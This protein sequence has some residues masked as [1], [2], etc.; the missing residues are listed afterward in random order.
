M[1]L[2]ISNSFFCLMGI[3]VPFAAQQNAAAAENCPL[4]VSVQQAKAVAL[5]DEPI[6][7]TVSFKNAASVE[8][9]ISIAYPSLSGRGYPGL[10]IKST[11]SPASNTVV[12]NFE[13]NNLAS[14]VMIPANSSWTV[15]VYLQRFAPPPAEANAEMFWSLQ[16]PCIDQRGQQ[17]GSVDQHGAVSIR[18]EQ[19][20]P[21]DL[22][23]I[24]QHYS[25]ISGTE[26]SWELQEKVEALSVFPSPVVI[27][28]LV[29][30]ARLGY[31]EQA[32]R[33]LVKFKD[34]EQARRMVKTALASG[35]R[36]T[37]RAALQVS[38]AW[39]EPLD[40]SY[41]DGLLESSKGAVQIE[42]LQYI[43]QS[44]DQRYAPALSRLASSSDQ[45]VAETAKQVLSQLQLRRR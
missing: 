17:T 45:S 16:T 15:S 2:I 42:F 14:N 32:Y 27:P 37:V 40:V 44:E 34:N 9:G 28:E 7:L 20:T 10:S 18:T 19:G 38:S 43:Q 35:D 1:K 31:T 23:K 25:D 13:A 41:V 33:A 30:L 29:T 39:H 21:Q 3:L 12:N 11:P 6:E 24:A 5:R 26:P 36:P 4:S 22:Q 8:T